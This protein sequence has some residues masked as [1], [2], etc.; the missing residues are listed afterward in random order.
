MEDV[1][2]GAAAA[3]TTT[4]APA[5]QPLGKKAKAAAKAAKAAALEPTVDA[6]TGLRVRLG[7]ALRDLCLLTRYI[8]APS[9]RTSCRP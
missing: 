7:G 3:S 1:D 8:H 5:Q 6:A 2:E 9:T 4:A